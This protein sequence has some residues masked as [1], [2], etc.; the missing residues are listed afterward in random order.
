M[1]NY[2]PSACNVVAGSFALAAENYTF[3]GDGMAMNGSSGYA[4]FNYWNADYTSWGNGFFEIRFK[5]SGDAGLGEEKTNKLTDKLF[6][7]DHYITKANVLESLIQSGLG[8]LKITNIS[9]KQKPSSSGFQAITFK[10]SF[11]LDSSVKIP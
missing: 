1:L 3:S 4:A 5:F 10:D 6:G 11:L 2:L 8:D 7:V 9:E